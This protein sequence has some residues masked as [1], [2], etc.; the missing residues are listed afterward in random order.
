MRE[1][2]SKFRDV[3]YER[4]L[5]LHHLTETGERQANWILTSGSSHTRCSKYLYKKYAEESIVRFDVQS[6]HLYSFSL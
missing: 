1:G 4:L 6:G 3:I 5:C 2:V